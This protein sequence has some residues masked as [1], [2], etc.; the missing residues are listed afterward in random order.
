MIVTEEEAK[1]KSCPVFMTSAAITINAGSA[2][3]FAMRD[4]IEAVDA[5]QKTINEIDVACSGSQCMMWVWASGTQ[6]SPF[7]EPH[8]HCGLIHQPNK[9]CTHP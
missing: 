5:I 7:K 6:E 2:M 4:N 1:K 3:M 9:E 8:G